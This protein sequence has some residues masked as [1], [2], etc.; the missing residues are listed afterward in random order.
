MDVLFNSRL[1]ADFVLQ[2]GVHDVA[3]LMRA[4]RDLWYL[5]K[6][7]FPAMAFAF[8][9]SLPCGALHFLS[10]GAWCELW[11]KC[12]EVLVALEASR[13]AAD[14]EETA[15][16]ISS[17]V[18]YL[19]N[20]TTRPEAGCCN[21]GTPRARTVEEVA[22][23]AGYGIYVAGILRH[24]DVDPSFCY[25]LPAALAPSGSSSSD[26]GDSFLCCDEKAVTP[27]QY[28][29]VFIVRMDLATDCYAPEPTKS[30]FRDWLI[31]P[32]RD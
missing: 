32:P 1:G 15:R 29:H 18:G 21:M 13:D 20:A 3:A 27:Y 5:A 7:H 14:V 22:G 19:F 9:R 25:H 26:R 4:N 30:T 24:F 2:L 12:T 17:S 28:G 16:A 11:T 8:T 6:H 23:A 10:L 31:R